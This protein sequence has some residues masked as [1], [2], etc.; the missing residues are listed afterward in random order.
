M[1]ELSFEPRQQA[2]LQGSR[3]ASVLPRVPLL[4]SEEETGRSHQP[5]VIDEETEAERESTL[6]P[7]PKVSERL[8][9]TRIRPGAHQEVTWTWGVIPH[10][11]AVRSSQTV[12]SGDT[13]IPEVAWVRAKLFQSGLTLCDP[14]DCSPPSS[15]VHADCAGKNTGVGCHALLQGLFPPQGSNPRLLSLAWADRFFTTS[16]TWEALRHL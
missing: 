5:H 10:P 14:M 9:W 15:F 3:G 4:T 16:A 6:C 8:G 1:G 11:T 12:G 2:P 7:V 13:T